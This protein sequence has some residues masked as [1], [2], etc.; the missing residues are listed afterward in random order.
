M[1][2]KATT[3]DIF[4]IAV[5]GRQF[6]RE[7]GEEFSFDSETAIRSLQMAIPSDQFFLWVSEQDGDVVGF[8]AGTLSGTLFSKDKVASELVWYMDPAHR[9]SE[10]IKLVNKFEDWAKANGCNRVSMADVDLLNS[11]SSLYE[12]KGYKLYEKAYVKGI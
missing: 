11:L 2:R 3:E 1:I 9:G 4:S 10:A 6:V 12:R 8:L 5:L 7:V